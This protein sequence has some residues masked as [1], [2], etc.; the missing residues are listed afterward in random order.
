VRLKKIVV[1]F[2]DSDQSR[3]ALRLAEAVRATEDGALVVAVVD[4]IDPLIGDALHWRELRQ[5][6]YDSMFEAA[7]KALGSTEFQR[8]VAAG[9]VP[10]ALDRIA[11]AEEADL[12]VVGSTH[13]GKLG[14]V[15]PGS[16]GRRL[17]SGAPCAVAVAPNGYREHAPS[18][19]T[20]VGVGY[21]GRTEAKAALGLAADLAGRLGAELRLITVAPSGQ[22]F[23]PSGPF[24]K[25]IREELSSSLESAARGIADDVA[26]EPALRYGHPPRELANEGAELDLLVIGSRSY[27]PLRRVLLGSVAGELIEL[28]P[29]P[30]IVLPRTGNV[31]PTSA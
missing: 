5:E 10:G 22:D 4:E 12:I 23:I 24:A 16:V 20:R 25:A 27:G 30:V 15:L 6:Y 28:A 18:P 1:G 3:D 26:V 2:D 21:D 31:S 7:R 9:S 19:V 8:A 29:C 17:L 13:R 14:Q 11:E